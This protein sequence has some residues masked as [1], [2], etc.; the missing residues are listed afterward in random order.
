MAQT[1]STMLPLGTVAPTFQLPD[2]RDGRWVSL[3]AAQGSKA[4][5]IMFICNHCPFVLHVKD[6]IVALAADYQPRGL[7][8]F[9]ISSND[10][11]THPA[12]SPAKMRDFA[13]TN[14]FTFPY[15]YDESQAVA[16]AYRAACTPDFFLFDSKRQL[17]Y[18][19]Q[20]DDTRPSRLG[21]GSY[22][23]PQKPDGRDL[24]AAIE[25]VLAGQPVSPQ[26]KPSIGC[27]IKWK[28]GNEPV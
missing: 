2:T 11:T 7:A 17:V 23:S 22:Q 15:L 13:T 24:R 8:L 25:A 16:H 3:D 20:L 14:H 1:A 28:A 10:I 6:Q 21:P 26:Q 5:L 4:I 18:R 9:A 12:D 27:N 19:G